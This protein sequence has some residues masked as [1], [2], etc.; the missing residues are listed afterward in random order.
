[1]P[2]IVLSAV[3][4]YTNLVIR[5]FIQGSYTAMM[6]DG[7]ATKITNPYGNKFIYRII[8]NSKDGNYPGHFMNT[9]MPENVTTGE[10]TADMDRYHHDELDMIEDLKA[11]LEGM[12]SNLE[13]ITSD[14]FVRNFAGTY[15][16][17]NI[18]TWVSKIPS[19]NRF[20]EANGTTDSRPQVSQDT[21]ILDFLFKREIDIA[22]KGYMGKI[23]AFVNMYTYGQ[24]KADIAKKGGYYAN[25][26][27]VNT[28]KKPY[29]Y[30]FGF[31]QAQTVGIVFG[32]DIYQIGNI[33]VVPVPS[34]L[35]NDAITVLPG[36]DGSGNQ[37]AGGF[38]AKKV[39]NTNS[40]VRILM[41]PFGVVPMA[42]K[43]AITQFSLPAAYSMAYSNLERQLSEI[44]GIDGNRV[45]IE[46]AGI[47]QAGMFATV[48][49]RFIYGTDVFKGMEKYCYSLEKIYDS[50]STD[51]TADL[52]NDVGTMVVNTQTVNT[53]NVTEQKVGV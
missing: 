2:N 13:E 18:S 33:I 11:F 16:A 19:T 24:L 1:M 38:T 31:D 46:N 9:P 45:A 35:M 49:M 51:M 3:N 53:Q 10:F 8:K 27:L 14:G 4:N 37:T 26:Q 7:G 25:M 52:L 30:T 40:S 48:D 5:D 6:L 41:M 32:Y 39:T 36:Y 43:L 21:S 29:Q 12:T 50:S 44:R 42:F 47:N 28:E 20:M 15:D 17:Y 34:D 22:N 23:V